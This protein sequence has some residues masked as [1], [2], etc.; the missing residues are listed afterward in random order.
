MKRKPI[1]KATKAQAKKK[2]KAKEKKEKKEKN[3][4]PVVK[5]TLVVSPHRLQKP[6]LSPPLVNSVKLSRWY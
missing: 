5:F 1:K 6:H 4:P 2:A 3:Y